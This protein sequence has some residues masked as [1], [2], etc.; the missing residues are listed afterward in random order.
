MTLESRKLPFFAIAVLALALRAGVALAAEETASATAAASQVSEGAPPELDGSRALVVTA[1]LARPGDGVVAGLAASGEASRFAEALAQALFREVSATGISVS[2]GGAIDYALPEPETAKA[3][4]VSSGA[5]W[6][7][8]ARVT[9]EDRRLIWRAAV[10]DGRDGSLYGADAFSAYAGLSV[11]PL[12]D[13]SARNAALA[14]KKAREIPE[15]PAPIGYRLSFASPDDGAIV[16]FGPGGEEAG[17]VAGGILEA[18][19]LPFMAGE[20]LLLGIEKEGYWP[21]RFALKVKAEPETAALPALFKKTHYAYGANY[22]MGRLLGAAASARWYPLPDLLYL[23]AENSLW[24]AYDFR[25]GSNPVLHDELRL[26]AAAYIFFSP[27]ARFRSSLGLGFSGIATLFTNGGV[28]D[29]FAFDLCLEPVFYT[30]EWHYPDWALVLEGRA[31]YSLGLASG[32]LPR[33][34]LGLGGSGGPLF[35]SLGVIFKL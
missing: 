34:W 31:P 15:R 30:L 17:L 21:R 1:Y 29:P 7:L 4:A 32:L 3:A 35:L 28:A 22:G 16:S 8:I 18:P 6:I 33:Q 2:R 20:R 26:G 10:Y 19:Y 24:A 23:R 25:P 13:A 14:S 11:L 5:R 9:L 27:E 12:L